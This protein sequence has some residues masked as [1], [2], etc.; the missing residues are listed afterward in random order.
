MNEI[1]SENILS[2]AIQIQ[3]N[4]AKLRDSES[5]E[6]SMENLVKTFNALTGHTLT[7]SEGWEFMV[8]LKMVRG[9][10]GGFN[11][12]DYVDG[13]SYFSL[14]G[15]EEAKRLKPKEVEIKATE[16]SENTIKIKDRY[17]C[18]SPVTFPAASSYPSP[19]YNQEIDKILSTKQ[20]Y[21]D[22]DTMANYSLTIYDKIFSV[23]NLSTGKIASCPEEQ[24]PEFIKFIA[25]DLF[26]AKDGNILARSIVL[27]DISNMSNFHLWYLC[28][29][30]SM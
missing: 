21:R 24:I 12:D 20:I 6:R 27:K 11:R 18:G 10:Q 2:D 16:N 8:L 26:E 14:L 22:P 13:A 29:I 1:F 23:K 5:G 15:E 9:R 4:R 28:N 7:V 19:C 3:R 17:V 30:K 25:P